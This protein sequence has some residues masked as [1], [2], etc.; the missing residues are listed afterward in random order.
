MNPLQMVTY[1]LPAYG[2]IQVEPSPSNKLKQDILLAKII[3][4]NTENLA[5]VAKNAG[6][7]MNVIFKGEKTS[8][9]VNAVTL[10]AIIESKNAFEVLNQ[11]ES[12]NSESTRKTRYSLFLQHV[13]LMKDAYY[14]PLLQQLFSFNNPWE[15]MEDHLLSSNLSFCSLPQWTALQKVIRTYCE[16]G[17]ATGKATIAILSGHIPVLP[18]VTIIA[19]YNSI[20]DSVPSKIEELFTKKMKDCKEENTEK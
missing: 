1:N 19:G 11:L 16:E 10:S 5:Q 7:F 15:V 14:K 2:T 18:L 6:S 20:Y 3:S 8:R 4:D 9:N 17:K 12:Q 13:D